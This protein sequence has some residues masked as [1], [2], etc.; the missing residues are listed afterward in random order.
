M[1]II[2]D[3]HRMNIEGLSG[4]NALSVRG[5]RIVC[6]G[7]TDGVFRMKKRFACTPFTFHI[8]LLMRDSG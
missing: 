3:Y 8:L 4:G 6:P 1:R 5:E 2:P 7:T